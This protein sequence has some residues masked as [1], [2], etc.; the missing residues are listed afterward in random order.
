MGRQN[1]SKGKVIKLL[2][3]HGWEL[4]DNTEYDTVTQQFANYTSFIDM[5]GDHEYYK[6]ADVLNWLGY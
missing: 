3:Q 2:R 5:V 1:I 6:L 4:W